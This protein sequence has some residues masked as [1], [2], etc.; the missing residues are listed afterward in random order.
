MKILKYF[1]DYINESY[2]LGGR[3][4]L[5]TWINKIEKLITTDILYRG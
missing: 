3:Q 5:Y 1:N 4:P 2:L